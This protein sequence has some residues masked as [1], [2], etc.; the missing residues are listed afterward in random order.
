MM[1]I[2]HFKHAD[3]YSNHSSMCF[4]IHSD[5]KYAYTHK[6]LYMPIKIANVKKATVTKKMYVKSS[7][8]SFA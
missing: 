4:Y 1:L 7:Y 8:L 2:S 6:H 3:L 5:L